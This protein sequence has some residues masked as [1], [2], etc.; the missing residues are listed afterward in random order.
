MANP[1]PWD[2]K[3]AAARAAIVVL[4][5]IFEFGGGLF[6]AVYIAVCAYVVIKAFGTKSSP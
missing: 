1:I 5:M 3:I 4:V 6:A 2:I